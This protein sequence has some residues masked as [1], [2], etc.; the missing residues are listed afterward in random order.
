[1]KWVFPMAGRGTRTSELGSFKPFVRIGSRL[2]L[3][4]LLRSIGS[5]IGQSDS[6]VFVT[7]DAYAEAHDV[8]A[9]IQKILSEEG[10]LN[11]FELVTT[12]ETPPGPAATVHSAREFISTDEPAIVVNC[13]QFIDFDLVDMAEGRCGF[14]PVYTQFGQKSSFVRIENG[15]I[16]LIVEKE[17]ISN[18][19]SAG[20]YAVSSGKALIWAIERQF[21]RDQR[22]KGE[23]YV[24]VALNNLIEKG[25]RLYPCA[26]RAKYDLGNVADIRRFETTMA[27]V[28]EAR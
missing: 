13:D 6:M 5:K 2:M 1:M 20:V 24:G 8:R 19:A 11:G 9:N 22:T 3:G 15:L 10:I 23:F 18:I 16:T 28:C 17:N 4:W 25:Y 7:T 21:E 27:T 12:L 14:L 26:V